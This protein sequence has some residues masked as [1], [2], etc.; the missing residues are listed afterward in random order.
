MEPF[1]NSLDRYEEEIC[2]IVWTHFWRVNRK[3]TDMKSHFP[4]WCKSSKC[5]L[6]LWQQLNALL[7]FSVGPW[8]PCVYSEPQF[9]N[10]KH[11]ASVPECRLALITPVSVSTHTLAFV[12]LHGGHL[13]SKVLL[14]GCCSVT[15]VS[16]PAGWL[17]QHTS[18]HGNVREGNAVCLQPKLVESKEDATSD[19]SSS[20]WLLG[21]GQIGLY[22][23]FK[24]DF[25]L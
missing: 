16:V 22:A 9:C 18:N 10:Y 20:V 23:S 2:Q 11:S 19:Q 24:M 3:A 6:R 25:T 17:E 13:S 1:M 4:S 21:K 15:C 7:L 8:E 5:C 14:C 12:L